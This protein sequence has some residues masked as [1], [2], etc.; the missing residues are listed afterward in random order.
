MAQQGDCLVWAAA[1]FCSGLIEPIYAI[2]LK[3]NASEVASKAIMWSR[4]VV[5]VVQI[6]KESN[7][8]HS[9]RAQSGTSRFSI[10]SSLWGSNTTSSTASPKQL[11]PLARISAPLYCFYC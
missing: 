3:S 8:E 10:Y 9:V 2:C 11:F 4:S 1:T 7:E 6:I 5:V